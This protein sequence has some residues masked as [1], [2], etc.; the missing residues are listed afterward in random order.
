VGLNFPDFFKRSSAGL[1]GIDISAS[2]VKVVE[3]LPGQK[4]AIRLERYAIEPIERGAVNDGNV[5]NP[6]LVAAALS[7]A[8]RRLGTRTREVALAMPASA[9]I[10]KRIMLPAGLPEED[11]ELQVETEASQYIPF[12]IEEVNL[13][14]QILGPSAIDADEIEVLLAASRK[15]KVEDRVAVAEMCG[16]RPVVVDIDSYAARIA[17]EH[18]ASFLPNGGQGQII[19]VFDIGQSVTTVSIILNG[20]TLFEREQ[21]FGGQDLTQDLMR[22]YGLSPEEAELKKR[23]GELPE[24][25][26]IDV[27]EPYIERG[28]T[29]ITRALQF[30]FTST[31]YSRVDRI[32]LAGGACIVPGLCEGV[33]ERT[34]VPAEILSPFQGM[35]IADSVRERQLRL[36]APALVTACGLAL[37]RF[38]A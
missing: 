12:A 13:D 26:R 30:F 18:V 29:D 25:Y 37:R 27:L 8:M 31:P 32:Y 38:D 33:S 2:S 9:V 28:V 3:L 5:E 35:E 17:L 4:T 20:A 36:D 34:Q 15:D 10:T 11:Y 14:F 7:R 22:L 21:I 16:L 24:N 1:L 19:A 23:T 6:E